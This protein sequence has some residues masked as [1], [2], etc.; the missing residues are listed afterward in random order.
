MKLCDAGSAKE[1]KRLP[2]AE[3]WRA[4]RVDDQY[5][6]FRFPTE[7]EKAARNLPLGTR[8]VARVVDQATLVRRP[9]MPPA[10]ELVRRLVAWRLT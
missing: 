10:P 6:L 4:L 5:V 1:I 7:A 2:G 9:G 3:P 8:L